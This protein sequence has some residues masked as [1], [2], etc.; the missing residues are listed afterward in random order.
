MPGRD[1]RGR[2]RRSTTAPS[3]CSRG[4]TSIVGASMR[5][6]RA[7]V[8]RAMAEM[9]PP[10]PR[11]TP[12]RW[13]SGRRTPVRT[14][15]G[16]VARFAYAT[17][18]PDGEDGF[19]EAPGRRLPPLGAFRLPHARATSATSARP[20]RIPSRTSGPIDRSAGRSSRTTTSRSRSARP[21]FDAETGRPLR[22]V[23]LA[24]AHDGQMSS[25]S[26]RARGRTLQVAG[27]DR[28]AVGAPRRP[29]RRR[30][31]HRRRSRRPFP[32]LLGLGSR[33]RE[34]LA[35]H[36]IRALVDRRSR[37]GSAILVHLGY[38]VA[39]AAHAYKAR[40]RPARA[41]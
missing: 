34:P 21:R 35:R 26:R 41:C 23:S 25:R 12:C 29:A 32:R 28:R 36:R 39:S 19:C 27:R 14:S 11:A 6:G 18:L 31:D 3:S 2:D 7:R 4:A 9:H 33:A 13:F 8:T 40:F 10:R 20:L 17:E 16:R 22:D 37:S 1:P 15:K 30:R 38:W 24:R 5:S